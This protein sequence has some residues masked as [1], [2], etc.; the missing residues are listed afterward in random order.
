MDNPL[1]CS[2]MDELV[3]LMN[4]T[5]KCNIMCK[6]CGQRN[7]PVEVKKMSMDNELLYELCLPL[8]E[9]AKMIWLNGG[10]AFCHPE[11]FNYVQF[12]S[13]KYPR[14]TIKI[15]S[16]GLLF[17]SKW[18]NLAADNLIWIHISLN[19]S[20]ES[21]YADTCWDREG[22]YAKIKQN[23]DSYIALLKERSLIVFAPSISM[24]INKDTAHDIED[25]VLLALTGQYRACVFYFDSSEDDKT[26]YF[27]YPDAL[28]PALLKLLKLERVL[29]D[30]FSMFFRF[31]IPA[32]ELSLIEK[33]VE[34]MP[35]SKLIKEYAEISE[36]AEKR[37][38]KKE[39]EERERVR[40][41][42]GKK[43]LSIDEES[44]TSLRQDKRDNKWVCSAPFNEIEISPDR[45]FGFC[46]LLQRPRFD[47]VQYIKD[48]SINW[49]EAY[50]NAALFEVRK[51]FLE[52]RYHI[53]L[54]GCP[55]KAA[56]KQI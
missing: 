46:C 20:N 3:I 54:E 30:K 48:G 32:T 4:M 34:A 38:I 14:S 8:Y 40:K 11:C 23:L 29:A 22:A 33:E 2:S 6:F 19:G 42:K 18:H 39:H 41:A 15:Q 5:Y 49:D 21:I 13:S 26:G 45:T 43:A 16:N 53:C 9:R 10:E 17:D 50:N 44:K 24:V 1:Y 35:M 25:F 47:M 27:R 52:N 12:L 7:L 55:L 37:S 56:N 36:L 28:R 31:R 51:D